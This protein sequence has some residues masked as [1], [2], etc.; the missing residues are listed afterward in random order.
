MRP[1]R[2]RPDYAMPDSRRAQNRR[3]G[4]APSSVSQPNA[5]PPQKPMPLEGFLDQTMKGFEEGSVEVG[6][7]FGDVALKA[8]RGAFG[9]FLERFHVQG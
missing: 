7:G 4:F 2:Y 5:T 1:F 9:G 3:F 8:W 6:V